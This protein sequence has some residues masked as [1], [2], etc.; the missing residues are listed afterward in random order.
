MTTYKNERSRKKL[1]VP[2]VAL[3][4]CATA[5]VGLG[6]A[7]LVSDVTNTNNVITSD[8]LTAKLVDGDNLLDEGGFVAAE[9]ILWE[10][11]QTDKSI[12]YTANEILGG[13][14]LKIHVSDPTVTQVTM[15]YE[16]TWKDGA[17]TTYTIITEL[18]VVNNTTSVN[19]DLS[20]GISDTIVLKSEAS[21]SQDFEFTLV[22]SGQL[23]I[24]KNDLV[25]PY[26]DLTY[27]IKIYVTQA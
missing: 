1:L 14:I 2:V 3:L 19:K 4:L 16:I 9:D 15:K 6:Y 20:E 26:D 10:S 25:M 8:G 7:A 12:T 24:T 23:S 11:S 27:D 5:M 18:S 13:A 22:L 21:E 17:D